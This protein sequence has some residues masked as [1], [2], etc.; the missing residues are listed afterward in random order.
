MP[1]F[2]IKNNLILH[3]NFRSDRSLSGT[4]GFHS[5]MNVVLVDVEVPVIS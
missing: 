2:K 1:L 4:N 3:F 5:H